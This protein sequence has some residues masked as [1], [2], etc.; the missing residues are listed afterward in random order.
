M[1]DCRLRDDRGLEHDRH[2]LWVQL[3]AKG[4]ANH[5]QGR[6]NRKAHV[7]RVAQ[8]AHA[9]SVPA[10]MMSSVSYYDGVTYNNY[11]A[12]DNNC[13]RILDD[14]IG[15]V[16]AELKARGSGMTL[17]YCSA[18]TMAAGPVTYPLHGAVDPMLM[19]ETSCLCAL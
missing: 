17:C 3:R 16:T 10:R 5:I 13:S 18:R 6:A 15:N 19:I 8:H 1:R 9:P 4:R 11:S 14:G 2:L 12:H 7:P